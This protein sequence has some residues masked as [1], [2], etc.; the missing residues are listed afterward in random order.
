VHFV[1]DSLVIE[2]CGDRRVEPPSGSKR[3][4]CPTQLLAFRARLLGGKLV[5]DPSRANEFRLTLTVPSFQLQDRVGSDFLAKPY[6]A[7]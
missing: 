5:I 6:S 3:S 4:E 2:L 7:L 1:R